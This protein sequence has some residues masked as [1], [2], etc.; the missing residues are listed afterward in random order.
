M[1]SSYLGITAH[2]YSTKDHRRHSVTLAMRRMP[3]THTSNNI[4]EIVESVL[5][6]WDIPSSKISA[7]ITDNGSNMIA[8][9]RPQILEPEN[10]DN[11]EENQD[12]E[13]SGDDAEQLSREFEEKES[14]H[15]IAF[16]G[17]YRLSCYTH[18]L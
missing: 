6:E 5:E 8:A 11:T 17:L 1:S 10:D 7:T 12:T 18:T 3:Q 2:F 14:E 13:E 9:F 16:T 15:D 4:H